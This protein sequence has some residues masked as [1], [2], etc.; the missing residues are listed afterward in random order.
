MRKV[1]KS[2]N[3]ILDRI[4]KDNQN[5]IEEIKKNPI[6]DKNKMNNL[7]LISMKI[8]SKNLPNNSVNK[9]MT[10][11]V[12]MTQMIL[13]MSKKKEIQAFL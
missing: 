1:T 5:T 7:N 2:L 9:M 10:K 3:S 11:I 8:Y 6:K 12:W 13:T 4:D